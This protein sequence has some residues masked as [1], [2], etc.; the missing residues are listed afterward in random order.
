[1]KILTPMNSN[2]ITINMEFNCQLIEPEQLPRSWLPWNGSRLPIVLYKDY[3]PT[4][5]VP[6]HT[7][8]ADCRLWYIQI[9]WT[10]YYV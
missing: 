10:R 7:G 3:L 5:P 6:V 4:Y 1:M 9:V 8:E 2:M